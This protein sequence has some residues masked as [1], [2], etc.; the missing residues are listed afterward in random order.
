MPE[1]YARDGGEGDRTLATWRPMYWDYIES[2]CRKIGREPSEKA[3][4]V[5][6]RFAVVYRDAYRKRAEDAHPGGRPR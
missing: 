5:M 2:E 3:P 1:V 4:L 6:E